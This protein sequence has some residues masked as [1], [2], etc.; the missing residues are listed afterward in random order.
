MGK[1]GNTRKVNVMEMFYIQ[2]MLYHNGPGAL[3]TFLQILPNLIS[4]NARLF[5]VLNSKTFKLNTKSAMTNIKCSINAFA[6]FQQALMNKN[7]SVI[8]TNPILQSWNE[9]QNHIKVLN[10]KNVIKYAAGQTHQSNVT[11]LRGTTF[12]D[13]Q[14]LTINNVENSTDNS[15]NAKRIG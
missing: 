12:A 11:G 3:P 9:I 8:R 4:F 5:D 14:N 6:E 13:Y 2:F 10:T 1:D 7:L 15:G